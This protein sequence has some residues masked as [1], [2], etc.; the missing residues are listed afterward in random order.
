M[1]VIYTPGVCVCFKRKGTH[2]DKKNPFWDAKLGLFYFNSLACV[3]V[4]VTYT[5]S[6]CYEKNRRNR[7]EFFDLA[8]VIYTLAVFGRLE[9][10]YTHLLRDCRQFVSSR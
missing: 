3:S 2:F 4:C 5:P 7:T 8:S 9:K 6:V 10:V 1:C